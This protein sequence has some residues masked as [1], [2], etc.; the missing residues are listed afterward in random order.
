MN[1]RHLAYFILLAALLSAASG[2][3][4]HNASENN[5]ASIW[6]LKEY[7]SFFNSSADDGR[8]PSIMGVSISPSSLKMGSPRSEINAYVNDGGGV[9]MVYADIGSRMHLMLDLDRN[10]R[11]TGYCGSNLPP[12]TYNVTIIAIDKAGNAAKDESAKFTITNPSDLNANG[13]ED[14]LEDQG[15]KAQ[16]VIVLH[17]GNMSDDALASSEF[18]ILPVSALT[19][20]SDSLERIA[21]TDGVKAI[22]KDQKLKILSL[23]EES[24]DSISVASS[25]EPEVIDDPRTMKGYTGEGVSVALIDTG[26]DS[27]HESLKGRILAF[28]DFVNNQTYAYD[29]NGHGTHCASLIAGD[30]GIGVAPGSDLV[31]I[32]VMDRDGACYTSDALRALEWCIENKDLYG[33]RVVS[34]SVG[35]ESPSESSDLLNE[36]CNRM[37]DEGM[38]MCVAAGNSGPSDS[39]IVVPG[40][41]E[42]VITVGAVSSYGEIFEL[43][44]RGPTASG[45]IKPDIVTLG[46]DVVS[47]M[48]GAETGRSSV[49]GTSMSAPL[50]SGAA[51]ILLEADGDLAPSDVKRILL[52]TADDLGEAGPDNTFGY[53]ALNLTAALQSIDRDRSLLAPPALEEV[54]LSQEEAQAGVP[55]MI[56]AEAIGEIRTIN[57]NIIGPDRNMEIPMD[58]F[59]CNGVFSARWETSFWT[60]GDYQIRVDLLGMF[61]EVDHMAVPFHLQAK[62]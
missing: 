17:E 6:F 60:A 51:T 10:G 48:A 25:P 5:K 34:F 55:V 7:S 24:G 16:K 44:S 28:K 14:S 31:V 49:S 57:A 53:G 3:P 9:E 2:F 52:K 1:P 30:D 23:P 42:K 32:K 13:I 26:A 37:T 61:G 36:A 59:D 20:P 46:V 29:D 62:G 56:E 33:I 12:G 45:E 22:Y 54:R 50:V 35:G 43:S 19:V 4:A 15:G 40:D 39:S 38:V 41:A 47:A 18:K 58:D 21:G 8:P 27:N 11:Y